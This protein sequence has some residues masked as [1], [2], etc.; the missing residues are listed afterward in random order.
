MKWK[1]TYRSIILDMKCNIKFVF[2]TKIKI[3]FLYFL[4]LGL[5]ENIWYYYG[6]RAKEFQFKIIIWFFKVLYVKN[7]IMKRIENEILI[8]NLD[9]FLNILNVT[10]NIQFCII[11]FFIILNYQITNY[12][13]PYIG[14]LISIL[15]K[16]LAMKWK[17][18]IPYAHFIL[19]NFEVHV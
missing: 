19:S 16:E 8:G 17:S 7:A 10:N 13:L 1:V 12:Y 4:V 15:L 5:N 11:V 3:W 18:I 2:T 9:S 6:T 14:E